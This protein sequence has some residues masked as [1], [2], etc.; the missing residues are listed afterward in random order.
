[1]LASTVSKPE[2]CRS[3]RAGVVALQHGFDVWRDVVEPAASIRRRAFSPTAD[4][5]LPGHSTRLG[6]AARPFMFLT[7]LQDDKATSEG[8]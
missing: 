6:H 8:T 4:R 7:S 2:Q 5:R 1:M 3:F